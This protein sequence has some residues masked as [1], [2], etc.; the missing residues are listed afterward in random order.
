MRLRR[1]PGGLGASRHSREFAA[2]EDDG[3]FKMPSS[4]RAT[5][6][7]V[8]LL[9]PLLLPGKDYVTGVVFSMKNVIP[10]FYR[11]LKTTFMDFLVAK[12]DRRLEDNLA[13]EL[14]WAANRPTS[15]A[16]SKHPIL[17]DLIKAEWPFYDALT[18]GELKFLDEYTLK[19]IADGRAVMLNQS[20]ERG[21]GI[22]SSE[23]GILHP[24]IRNPAIHF[25]VDTDK[26]I[27]RWLSGYEMLVCQ[28]FPVLNELSNP[29]G[30]LVRTC[31]FG[32]VAGDEDIP[33]RYRNLM[34]EA[35]GDAMQVPVVGAVLVYVF[36]CVRFGDKYPRETDIPGDLEI[37]RQ[38]P[39]ANDPFDTLGEI[40]KAKQLRKGKACKRR[41]QS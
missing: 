4:T 29:G 12:K 16:H 27:K 41:R 15:R 10:L 30:Q 40:F 5:T 14:A 35:A 2:L 32:R 31:S 9:T 22:K 6:C 25:V 7:V 36:F 39:E 17:R 21:Y 18:F 33:Q 34:V 1:A 28:G 37:Q 23:D 38:R 11:L 3:I 19:G 26:G 20:E 24:L 13:E 8:A